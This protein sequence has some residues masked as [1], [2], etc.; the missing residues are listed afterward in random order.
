MTTFREAMPAMVAHEGE[1]LGT[2]RHVDLAGETV[3]LHE[4]WTRCEFPDGGPY[5]YVQYN[6]L[7]WPD[8]RTLERSFGGTFRDGRLWWD[9]DRFYGHGW[10]TDEGVVLLRLDRRDEPGI[11]FV[12][13]I[14]L[15]A[16][17]ATRARTWQWF[18]DGTP[19]RRTLCDEKRIAGC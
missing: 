11:H 3:D 5:A 9:T 12:E 16:D 2:Y 6:R 18:R 19:F 14:S 15:S 7:T 1:W 13:M 4:T 8:G 10:Q 17:G